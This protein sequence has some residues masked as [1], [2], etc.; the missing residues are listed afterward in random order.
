[1]IIN[2]LLIL[3]IIATLVLALLAVRYCQGLAVAQHDMESHT[4]RITEEK[5]RAAQ[6]IAD[7][8]ERA[9]KQITD[10]R[11]RAAQQ[12]AEEKANCE[13]L[14]A[15]E[16]ARCE[17]LL[18]EERE[19]SAKD[20]AEWEERTATQIKLA[21][22][23]MRKQF[24]D[25]M[26]QRTATLKTQNAEQMERILSPMKQEVERL[27]KL[28]DMN[29][30]E[31]AR[32]TEGIINSIK[33]MTEHDQ[34]RDKLTQDLASALKNRGK[35]QG[36][37]GEQVLENILRD[38][39]LR[40]GSEYVIQMNVKSET[41]ANLR[42]DVVVMGS[43]GMKMIIDSKVSLTA[44]SDY[45][46]AETD[47]E[48]QQAEKANYDSIWKHVTELAAKD[49]SKLVSGA[50]PI[51]VMFVP[52]EGSYMLAMN[53]DQ[54]LGQKAYS[55]NVLVV[56]PTNLMMTLTLINM[57]WQNTRMNKNTQEILKS[58]ESLYEKYVGF[59][60]NYSK[61]GEQIDR[62]QETYNTARGQLNTGRGNISKQIEGLR[63]LG[64][65]SS[66]VIPESLRSVSDDNL[67][68]E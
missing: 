61:L 57:T 63:T 7:E 39:G 4:Q 30:S 16:K 35:V 64:V 48:R 13:K 21:Q 14:L 51:V 54:N 58:A 8:C 41:G 46:S 19:R 55:K 47:E 18:A 33:M 34:K 5:Q 38:S 37:W 27:Q 60:S 62:L 40:E 53:Y 65:K 15:E 23:E 6:Q 52:N 59:A 32:N 67:L 20:K 2:I 22:T 42:P 25:E 50:A 66:K 12:I 56:N 11:E 31:Q 36:D 28:L 45:V 43:N 26:Q 3:F 29:K 49:Y 24:D 10:E 17:K 9:A 44:Y 1:M 68:E